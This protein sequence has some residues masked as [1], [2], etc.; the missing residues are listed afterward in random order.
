MK[1]KINHRVEKGNVDYSILA[2]TIYKKLKGAKN[3]KHKTDKAVHL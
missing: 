1:H 3:G 2:K